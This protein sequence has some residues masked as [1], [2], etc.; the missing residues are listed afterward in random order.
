MASYNHHTQ[1]ASLLKAGSQYESQI[2]AAQQSSSSR[3]KLIYLYEKA[4]P[5]LPDADAD[6][7]VESNQSGGEIP[8]EEIE[9]ESLEGTK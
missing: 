4:L 9:S 7:D 3:S 8:S 6:E 1:E 2:H 5:A